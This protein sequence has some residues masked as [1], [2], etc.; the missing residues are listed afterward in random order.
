[1][2]KEGQRTEARAG[3]REVKGFPA[4][5][6]LLSC[7]ASF[8]NRNRFLECRAGNKTVRV[9]R[10]FRCGPEEEGLVSVKSG[11]RWTL[12]WARFSALIIAHAE[13]V[14]PPPANGLLGMLQRKAQLF[15]DDL[16]IFLP[17]R[18]VV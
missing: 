9:E 15:V 10:E 11:E 5:P 3:N 13:L 12:L 1:M 4:H 17:I 7:S 6:Q 8:E 14:R 2:G 16:Q 18:D